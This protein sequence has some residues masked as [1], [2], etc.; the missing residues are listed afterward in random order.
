MSSQEPIN[1]RLIMV[2]LAVV[3]LCVIIPSLLWLFVIA[4]S[5]PRRSIRRPS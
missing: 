5:F 3:V 2:V 4:R 1:R